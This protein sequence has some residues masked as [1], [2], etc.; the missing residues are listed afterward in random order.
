MCG[1]VGWIDFT[2]DL[3]QE[4]DTLRRM[5]DTMSLR[6]PDAEGMWTGPNTALGHRRLSIID[7]EGGVQPA[8]TTHGRHDE[9][10]VLVY[11]GEVYNF[12]ELRSELTGRGHRFHTRSDTEVVLRSYVEWGAAC[13]ERFNG[14]FAFAIWDAAR[15]ELVLAR[16]RIG[17]KPL[18]Y[19][20][21]PGGIL[22]ASEP[23][24][25]YANPLFK[26]T[27]PEDR[28]PILFN[29]RL[30][31][32]GETPLRDLYEVRP[33]HLVRFSRSGHHEA[34]YWRLV[35]R[36]HHDDLATTVSTVRDLVEDIVDRQL[37]ADV[38]RAAML[39]GG[40]DSTIMS[41]L[42]H[43]SLN[44]AGEGPL[45]T[46]SVEFTG[47]EEDF[48]PTALRP[49]RDAPYARRAARYLGTRHHDVVLGTAEVLDALPAARRARDL[50]S[51][52]Q[53]DT[54]MYL[55]F[56][57]IRQQ[58]TVALSGEAADEI[59]GGYPWYHDERLV[60][61]DR[62]PWI[63]DAPRLAD[64]FTED[65]H[66]RVRP[67]DAEHDRYQALRSEV[68]RLAGETGLNARMREVMYFSLKGPLAYL[69]D[70]KDRMS[71]A[72]GLEVRV[73]YCDHRLVEYVWNVPWEMK[74]A[75]GHWK[76][77]LRLAF[78]DILPRETLD[79]LK[80]GYPGTHDP[81]YE[82]EVMR[83]IDKTLADPSSPLHG[84]FDP[85]RIEDLTRAGAATMTW[86]N[87]SHQ[88]LPVLEVDAWMR[89]YDVTL[90]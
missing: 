19:H 2:R 43:R 86:L 16:D 81:A 15:E 71:M 66:R 31:L 55:L 11:S 36:E 73:P 65:L 52:G 68:P 50:P 64:C 33:G 46:Y 78:A 8:V 44:R 13:V 26:R 6:G 61:R 38:P 58:S 34:P 37:V 87:A 53:F 30:A 10:V 24:G 82:A 3:R 1:I 83:S 67:A 88:L 85:Q 63:G 45:N 22:F 76:S 28:L 79:R 84:V 23:K 21:Y 89:Q 72:V 5:T 12:Q 48:R 51:L 80:S 59:F 69:L 70:R 29:A 75:D 7:L 27:V 39:S 62:F 90:A 47:D 40:L 77:L 20:P 4:R 57:T 42:A 60:Q 14:M 41:A 32:P 9:A 49:E 56:K 54:S 74:N 17:V 18:Y 25:I 35:S